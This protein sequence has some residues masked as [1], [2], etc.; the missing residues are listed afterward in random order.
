MRVRVSTGLFLSGALAISLLACDRGPATRDES[1]PAPSSSPARS[2]GC[3]DVP[4]A[5]DLKKLL[6][7]APSQ[8]GD[9]GGLNHGKAMW[10]ALVNRN[11]EICALAVST[12][13]AAA[14][15]PGS[16]GI[17]MA[18]AY[19]ANGFSTDVAPLS[20]PAAYSGEEDI[21]ATVTYPFTPVTPL[22]SGLAVTSIR[23]RGPRT[24]KP[25][26]SRRLQTSSRTSNVARLASCSARA[27]GPWVSANAPSPPSA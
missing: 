16:R 12:E 20:S 15:W 6:Q 11:G 27:A 10:G 17:A 2:R 9:A 4:K 1:R 26:R 8:N 24:S 21:Q 25:V 18:K 22:I 7:D 19:T 13:D 5:A 3:D 23:Q 14:T